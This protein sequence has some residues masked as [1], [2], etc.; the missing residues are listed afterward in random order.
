MS[1]RTTRSRLR[2]GRARLWTIG[3][4]ALTMVLSGGVAMAMAM[5]TTAQPGSV[6]GPPAT[7]AAVPSGARPTPSTASAPA[8]PSAVVPAPPQPCAPE[9]AVQRLPLRRRLAQLIMVGVDPSGPEQARR[10]VAAEQVGGIFIG[11]KATGLL[12]GGA[13]GQVREVAQLPL[14]VAVDEEG[15]RVQRVDRIAGSI[16]SAR[17]MAATKTPEQVRELA[18]KRGA[19]L[20]ASGIT[21]DFA[22]DADVSSEPD[23]AVIG[24]RSF[25][26]DPA[27]VTRYADAFASGLRDAGVVP[28]FKH[29]PGHGHASGDSHKGAVTTP[30]LAQLRRDDLLPYWQL[31]GKGPEAVMVG[32]LDVPGLTTPGA[33]SS[34]SPPALALLRDEFGY[35]GVAISDDLSG[36]RA[37]TN[38]MDLPEA[39]GRSLAAGVD[40]A[41]WMSSDRLGEVLDH[42]EQAVRTGA[43]PQSRVDEAAVRVLQLKGV[44]P[45]RL[46]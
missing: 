44:D 9:D 21:V 1:H 33:P 28:V 12:G 19:V 40:I 32:H 39:V 37:I 45:C 30:P 11:G 22:P 16:P 34:I 27:V 24:D 15:G 14:M 8:P 42:L 4:L 2:A 3:V 29:F 36:M 26:S 10:V 5:R 6:A 35:R 25:S 31:L 23:D 38:R 18:R 20:L 41:L 17:Q 43:L 7:A 46:P 13:L